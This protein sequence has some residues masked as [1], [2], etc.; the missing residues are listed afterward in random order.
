MKT[1]ILIIILAMTAA[2]AAAQSEPPSEPMTTLTI[3][4][5]DAAKTLAKLEPGDYVITITGDLKGK[6]Q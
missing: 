2:I 4:A 6:L 1:N 3:N 5:D